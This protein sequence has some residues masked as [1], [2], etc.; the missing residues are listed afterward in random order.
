MFDDKK[1]LLLLLQNPEKGLELLMDQWMGFVHTIVTGRLSSIGNSQD[2][3]ECV[4]DVFHEVYLTRQRIDLEKGSL[5]SYLAVL[6]RRT[7]IDAYRR[8][9]GKAAGVSLD[10]LSEDPVAPDADVE[11][12]VIDHEI[13]ELLLQTIQALGDPDSEIII[14]KYYFGQSSKSIAKA[15]GVK[16][17]TVNKKVSRALTKLEQSLGG[18]L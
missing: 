10:E 18:K 6:A 8:K 17:N 13:G 2:I 16:E 12:T 15:L 7:A 1:M 9:R 14:R 4:S 5:K 3:E 11:Q